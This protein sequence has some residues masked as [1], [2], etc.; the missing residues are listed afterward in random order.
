MAKSLSDKNPPWAEKLL[1][2][3]RFAVPQ[4]F[5]FL[6]FLLSIVPITILGIG[7]IKPPFLLIP[8]YYWAVF[9]PNI[10]PAFLVFGYGLLLDVF[11]GGILGFHAFI[12]IILQGFVKIQ[13]RI[14]MGQSFLTIWAGFLA[15]A[16]IDQFLKLGLSAILKG[17]SANPIDFLISGLVIILLYPVFSIILIF[18]HRLISHVPVS[19]KG[20]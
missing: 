4:L 9:R 7:D 3:L 18:L 2:A 11:T 8:I 6:L 17:M 20:L 13:R 5:T 14:L 16:I 19:K 12:Y 1:T 10:M 15:I